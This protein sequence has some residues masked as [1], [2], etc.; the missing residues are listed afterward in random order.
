MKVIIGITGASGVVLGLRSAEAAKALGHEVHVIYSNGAVET[1][2][3]EFPGFLNELKALGTR[4]YSENDWDAPM[5]SGSNV[6]DSMVIIPCSMKT[7]GLI[8][9]GIEENVITRAALVQLKERRR[10]VLVIREAPL[11]T[12]H[13]R[14]ML[15]VSEA[16]GIVMPASPGFY[17][18]VNDINDMINFIVGRALEAAGVG[19]SMYPRWA[20]NDSDGD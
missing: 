2:K 20:H 10:L 7:L 6:F 3:Y 5:A 8:A 15:S 17:G 4:L 11:S 18:R 9:G 16:G 19:N 14:N 12:I 13:I 1:A